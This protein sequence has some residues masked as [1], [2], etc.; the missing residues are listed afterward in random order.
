VSVYPAQSGEL[1]VV[2]RSAEGK[3]LVH[4]SV[5]GAKEGSYVGEVYAEGDE[6]FVFVDHAL[7]RVNLET[8]DER[9]PIMWL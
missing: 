1:Y 9:P 7:H 8:G 6:L 3:V 4:H 2:V 5:R